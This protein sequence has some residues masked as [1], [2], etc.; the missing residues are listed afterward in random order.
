[1]AAPIITLR[2]V[3]KSTQAPEAA[4]T[5]QTTENGTIVADFSAPGGQPASMPDSSR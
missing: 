3:A 4:M 1:M 5:A 2:Y